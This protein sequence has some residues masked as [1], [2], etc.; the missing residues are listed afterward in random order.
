MSVKEAFVSWS[1]KVSLDWSF[2]T[3]A[4]KCIAESRYSEN[5]QGKP[6]LE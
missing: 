3:S 5:Y 2:K 6:L 1:Y 4:T